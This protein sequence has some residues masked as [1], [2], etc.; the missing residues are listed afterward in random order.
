MRVFANFKSDEFSTQNI[1]R[2]ENSTTKRQT[3]PF[4]NGPQRVKTIVK[5]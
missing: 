4:K 2:T 5:N 1:Y 3:I